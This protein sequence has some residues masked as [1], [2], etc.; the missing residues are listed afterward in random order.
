M[1]RKRADMEAEFNGALDSGNGKSNGSNGSNGN[2]KKPKKVKFGAKQMAEI[3][4]IAAFVVQHLRKPTFEE[5]QECVRDKLSATIHKVTLERALDGLCKAKFITKSSMSDEKGT[6]RTTYTMRT[7]WRNPPEMA[8]VTTLLKAL[9]TNPEAEQIMAALNAQE[10]AG[11]KKARKEGPGDFHQFE[12]EI[13]TLDP[14]VGSMPGDGEVHNRNRTMF[15]TRIDKENIPIVNYWDRDEAT[16]LFRIAQDVQQGWFGCNVARYFQYG[17]W[18]GELVAFS[19]ILFTP[20]QDPV[21]IKLPCTG[22][23]HG[24]NAGPQFYEAILP[25]QKMT[26][27]FTAPT[28]KFLTAAQLESFIFEAGLR[29]RRGLSPSRGR[30]Y[31]RFAVIKFTD[32]GLV[33]GLT[34]ALLRS[35]IPD[36]I[37][38]ENQDYFLDLFS[39]IEKFQLSAKD[40]P[41]E[42]PTIN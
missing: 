32:L 7:V 35:D 3:G 39:R 34:T 42:P 5:I 4:V 26:M 10:E 13:V 8:H 27:R 29:P 14:W 20:D 28:K 19:P 37:W 1:A 15:P 17:P 25:G 6:G 24:Q 22:G 31:G 30:K 12:V 2:G 41:A 40:E 33:D 16:G 36:H 21:Q 23:P 38:Q 18:W 11:T 9:A